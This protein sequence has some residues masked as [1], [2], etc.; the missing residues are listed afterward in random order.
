VFKRRPSSH[1]QD[2]NNSFSNSIKQPNKQT[3]TP[4]NNKINSTL[5]LLVIVI[6]LVLLIGY[7][8]HLSTK[9]L[10]LPKTTSF[11]AE[12][13]GDVFK[14]SFVPT[15]F[16]ENFVAAVVEKT[17]PAGVEIRISRTVKTQLPSKLNDF[18]LQ[19]FS[20]NQLPTQTQE[21]VVWR[22]GS[23]F[24]IH[25]DG[26]I[27]TNAHVVRDADT[28][29]VLLSDGR[30]F[31]GKVL[32]TD[33]VTDIAVVEVPAQNLP[34][35]ELG[36]SQQVQVGE[37]AVA[38]GNPK[39]FDKTVTLGVVSAT[40]RF[41]QGYIQTDAAINPGNSGGA[42]LN[43]RGQVIGVNTAF[44]PNANKGFAVPINIAR[45]IAQQ[46]IAKGKVE[47]PHLGAYV[48][49]ITP[50]TLPQI[51]SNFNSSINVKTTSGILVTKIIPRSPASKA[52]LQVGDVIQTINNHSISMPLQVLQIIEHSGVD[53][54]LQIKLLRHGKVLQLKVRP[55]LPMVSK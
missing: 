38:I 37:W 4:L 39:G 8:L 32:G 20:D 40:S 50:E 26:K 17:L 41:A 22:L 7:T 11:G 13:P 34:T 5:Y 54:D 55:E 23:G 28:V 52:G 2:Y 18:L 25:S 6:E 29:N 21:Q 48:L 35:V 3:L 10:R 45:R 51:N 44:V 30:S 19:W 16:D 15:N 9:R 46:L 47:R 12:T 36:D 1:T 53:N 49:P 24:I 43:A 27:I 42:L 33:P 14:R 31:D